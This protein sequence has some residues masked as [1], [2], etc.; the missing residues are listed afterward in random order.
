MTQIKYWRDKVAIVTGGSSGI[1]KAT[2][3][4]LADRGGHVLVTGRNSSKLTEIAAAHAVIETLQADSADPVSATRI[5]ETAINRWGR[6]DLIVN[7]SGAGQPMPMEAYDA[8]L[9]AHMAAVN[10]VAPSLLIKEGREALRETSGAV[11]NIGTAVSRNPH[12]WW[13]IM[14]R[15][16]WHWSI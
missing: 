2:A 11:V 15:P 14:E 6:I 9:I 1:G 3:V 4:A 8:E 12:P 13:H 7:N 5:I 16:R 10:I